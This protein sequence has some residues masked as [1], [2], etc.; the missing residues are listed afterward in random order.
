MTAPAVQ[1][2]V[3]KDYPVTDYQNI[4]QGYRVANNRYQAGYHTG[5]DF[6]VGVGTPVYAAQGG[7]VTKVANTGKVGY[8]RQV[9]I[10]DEDGTY[11][12]YGHLSA[13]GVHEGDQLQ[14]G[15][16]IA[17]S[18]NTGN[19]TGAHL[20]FEVRSGSNYGSDIDPLRWLSMPTSA[21][22]HAGTV[23]TA[24]YNVQPLGT[25]T[26]TTGTGSLNPLNI[27]PGYSGLNTFFQIV[28]DGQFWIRVLEIAFGILL[29][30]FGVAIFTKGSFIPGAGQTLKA[31]KTIKK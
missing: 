19:S 24:G 12:L 14:T 4:T 17:Q 10:A 15:T 30:M 22:T 8:G 29:T 16:Q 1:S 28:T 23:Q 2:A 9:L 18:G 21:T 27:I 25:S 26:G 31:L 6:G 20:H 7:V 11:T 3:G 13:I 5:I